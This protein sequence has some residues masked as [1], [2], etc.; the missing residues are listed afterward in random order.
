MPLPPGMPIAA[1]HLPAGFIAPYL[2]TLA[3][4]VPEGPQCWRLALR[5]A[6]DGAALDDP[7]VPGALDPRKTRPSSITV[8][9]MIGGSERWLRIPLDLS[10]PALPFASQALAVVGGTP[11]VPFFGPTTGFIINF[12]PDWA[13]RFDLNGDPVQ[14]LDKGL[15]AGRC[16]TADGRE[17]KCRL[18]CW[19]GS[20][21]WCRQVIDCNVGKIALSSGR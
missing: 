9:G 15:H 14:Q 16:R 4:A 13:L 10:R 20:W 11:L 5:G 3:K 19:R 12:T 21:H 7:A 6:R 8:Y 18:R 17:R 2:P 1:P